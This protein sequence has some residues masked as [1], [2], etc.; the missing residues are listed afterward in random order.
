[1]SSRYPLITLYLSERCNS[2]CV[3][4]DYWRYGSRDLSLDDVKK[5]LPEFSALGVRDVLIS[6]G[7]PLLNRE[8]SSIAQLLHDAGFDL[9]L[10]TSGLSL[11]KSA[12]VVAPYFQSVPVSH[13]GACAGTYA[14]NRGVDA[15]DRVCDGIRAAAAAGIPTG[16]R[17]TLQKGNFRELSEF[18]SLARELDAFR[19]SFLAVDV[20]NPHAFA[21]EHGSAPDLALA[22]DE[23]AEFEACLDAL[24]V[25]HAEAFKSGFIAES[26]ARLRRIGAY[27]A[28]LQGLAPFPPVRCNAP[29]FSC[30]IGAD[31]GVS[32]C[33]FIP[34]PSAGPRAPKLEAAVSSNAMRE[35][36]ATIRSGGRPECVTCV[37]SMWRDPDSLADAGFRLHAESGA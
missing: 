17:V 32:P 37:C 5:M 35:L 24:E 19:I 3:S 10:L 8:W 15:F 12:G 14:A 31:G 6:G 7:E 1:M 18:V 28:A 9:W 13:A 4:C 26:P 25:R 33:F 16:L 22:A 11:A 27:F 20:S 21:R 30:V 2:R 34:G 36:R 29:E 23:L